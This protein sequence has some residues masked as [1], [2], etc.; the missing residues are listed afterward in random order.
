MESKKSNYDR[1]N[2]LL[3]EFNIQRIE[4]KRMISELESV[5]VKVDSII[6]KELDNRHKFIFVEKLKSITD[7][8]RTILEMRKEINKTIKDEI[9]LRK[10][11]EEASIDINKDA[12]NINELTRS[13]EEHIFK[14]KKNSEVKLM[15]AKKLAEGD[16]K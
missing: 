16:I 11:V 1:I 2:N 15:D 12:I 7:L 8:F 10:K 4:I 3:D 13:I 9:E 14:T 6:P 5:I